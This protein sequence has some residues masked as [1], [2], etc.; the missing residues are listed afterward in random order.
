[1]LISRQADA[2]TITRG[3]YLE[4]SYAL[5]ISAS[6]SLS[7]DISVDLP[8]NVIN[9]VS[10]DPPPGH[11]ASE[12]S[13]LI[14]QQ[15]P[16]K[17][18]RSWSID[19]L[20]APQVIRSQVQAPQ[21]HTLAE[22]ATSMDSLQL[23]D[24][25][26][27]YNQN[28]MQR[29]ESEYTIPLPGAMS[30]TASLPIPQQEPH[31]IVVQAQERQ[32]KHQMSLDCISTAIASATSRKV[33]HQRSM[34]SLRQEII[35]EH[36]QQPV[37]GS[38]QE[39]LQLDDL[40]DIPD[41]SFEQGPTPEVGT[42]LLDEESEDEIDCVLDNEMVRTASV[43][44]VPQHRVVVTQPTSA[45]PARVRSDSI[46]TQRSPRSPSAR[47]VPS[48]PS[49]RVMTRSASA[50]A[51]TPASPVRARLT[52][53]NPSLPSPSPSKVLKSAMRQPSIQNLHKRASSDTLQYSQPPRGTAHIRSR[54]NRL[55]H[56][57][58]SELDLLSPPE[59]SPHDTDSAHSSPSSAAFTP[60]SSAT[61]H[62]P[63]V[64]SNDQYYN[65]ALPNQMSKLNMST[66]VN[67]SP[68]SVKSRIAALEQGGGGL[69]RHASVSSDISTFKVDS[70]E[71]LG[72][73]NSVLSYKAPIWRG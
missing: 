18:A 33:G 58:P 6:G 15:P 35:E 57:S 49:N 66:M 73:Q 64:Y 28:N 12:L 68:S 63:E 69:K 3:Q 51:A 40:E 54:S 71:L 1:V 22:R 61:Q 37:Y 2:L 26:R 52:I 9:F 7:N 44:T 32:L 59:L 45:S 13:P 43:S 10:L 46:S 11:L 4:V 42:F 72:R 55:A 38:Q 70:A 62:S 25:N 47:S 34:S 60:P 36:P 8:I 14:E 24:L 39:T 41:D 16:R 30:R 23:S 65:S 21:L 5:K 56:I 67:L 19:Q 31:P 50:F 29:A 53:T 48:S 27:A 17:L 20:R